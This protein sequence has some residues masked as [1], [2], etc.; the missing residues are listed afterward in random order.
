MTVNRVT[1]VNKTVISRLPLNAFDKHYREF[2]MQEMVENDTKAP[3]VLLLAPDELFL[4]LRP[5]K[6]HLVPEISHLHFQDSGE[7]PS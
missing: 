6:V 3:Y 5:S 1:R 2:I 7:R 4:M